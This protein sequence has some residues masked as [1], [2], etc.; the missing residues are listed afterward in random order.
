[1]NSLAKQCQ[2]KAEE[3]GYA[4]FM[5]DTKWRE[6]CMAF[7]SSEKKPAFRARDFLNGYIS[8]WDSEWYHHIG[9]DYCAIEWLEIDPRECNRETI[10]KTLKSIGAPFEEG[11]DYFKVFGYKR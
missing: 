9:P 2:A 8:P 6:L 1:M 3:A 4:S 11:A 10:S 5:N 7:A